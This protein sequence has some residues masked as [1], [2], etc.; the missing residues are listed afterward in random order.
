MVR[1]REFVNLPSSKEAAQT[2]AERRWNKELLDRFRQT[3]L[4]ATIL[5]A[6]EDDIQAA[7]TQAEVQRVGAG[8]KYILQELIRRRVL[9]A[10]EI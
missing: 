10:R 1:K 3:S 4:Y 5:E 8:V 2:S 7:A 6:L 9:S